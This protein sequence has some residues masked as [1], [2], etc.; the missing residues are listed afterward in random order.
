MDH[1]R[2]RLE[3][4]F[5]AGGLF[6]QPPVQ[7]PRLHE[8]LSFLE[9]DLPGFHARA[10]VDRHGIRNHF[11]DCSG[12]PCKLLVLQKFLLHLEPEGCFGVG[13]EAVPPGALEVA[14]LSKGIP[15]SGGPKTDWVRIVSLRGGVRIQR[16][17]LNT[18]RAVLDHPGELRG[19]ALP[20][21][22]RPSP[23]P[24]AHGQPV[25]GPAY[26]RLT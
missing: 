20:S 22:R 9:D 6:E 7:L 21:W 23:L 2:Q 5:H 24:N 18:C 26:G 25:L 16:A 3:E 12:E 19:W 13:E 15:L 14:V 17:S 1:A 8:E 10:A 4:G 11:H